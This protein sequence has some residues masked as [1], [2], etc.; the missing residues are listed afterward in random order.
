MLKST[1]VDFKT[2]RLQCSHA[3]Y[4]SDS[5]E[6]RESA[7]RCDPKEVGSNTGRRGGCEDSGGTRRIE[8]AM[9]CCS[10]SKFGN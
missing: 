2:R 8:T 9:V 1:F 10:H 5:V 4:R 3:G 7:R 6:C